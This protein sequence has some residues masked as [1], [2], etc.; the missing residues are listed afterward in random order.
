MA[1]EIERKFLVN[2][3]NYLNGLVSQTR[4]I[5]GYLMDNDNMSIRIRME[6]YERFQRG[7]ITIKSKG[8]LS[9]DEYDIQIDPSDANELLYKC[10]RILEK[11]RFTTVYKGHTF[12]V[13]VFKKECITLKL[14]EI[15]LSDPNEQFEKPDWLGEE[16]TDCDK[17]YNENL[18]NIFN[19]KK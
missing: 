4:I 14:A 6:G 10:P 8:H 19:I 11:E 1:K 2:D 15:E 9:R 12:Y 5:Q 7:Y 18:A 13:D 17:Y 16:V 3:S